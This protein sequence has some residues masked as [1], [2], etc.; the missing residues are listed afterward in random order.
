MSNARTCPRCGGELEPGSAE[1]LCPRCLLQ[2]A[3]E[4]APE[5]ERLVSVPEP[6][7]GTRIRYFGDYELLQ[8]LGH[9]GM[10]VVYQARQ[11]SLNRLVAVKL[12]QGGEF[13]SPQ[14]IQRFRTEAEAAARL[15]HPNIVAIHE[16][17][18]YRGQHYFSMDYV[19]GPT[20]EEQVR[21]GP[22]PPQ[23]AAALVRTMA[24]AIHYAH[25]QGI[26]H[27]DLKPSNVLVD[28]LDQPRI[29]D[30]GLAKV[31]T[32]DSELTLTGQPL[33]SPGYMAPEQA[34]G[35]P[36]ELGPHSDLYALGAV[37]YHLLT[38]RA[39]F[40]AETL[41][42]VL[43]Q[44]RETEPV[45][46]RSLNPSVPRDLETI[47]LKCLEKEPHRRYR[48]AKDLAE[49]LGR[50]AAGKPILARPVSRPERLWRW[51]RRQPVQAS[52]AAALF[53]VIVL[54]FT[55][56]ILQWRQA[57]QARA[58]ETRMRQEA[59]AGRKDARTEAAKSQQVARFLEEMLEGVGPEVALGRDTTLMRAILD[60]TADRVSK[61]LTDQPEVAAQLQSTI[62]NTYLRLGVFDKAEAI[63]REA[64]RL[65][66]L[67]RGETNKA[68]AAS[69]NTLARILLNRR[70]A[71]DFAHA[72]ALARRAL[73]I[74][75]SISDEE[76]AEIANSWHMLGSALNVQGRK[77][78]AE[79]AHERA[80]AI[81]RRVLKEH[82]DVAFSLNNLSWVYIDQGKF[83]QAR[84]A[85][86]EALALETNLFGAEHPSIATSL[87]SLGCV[88]EWQGRL[89]EAESLER[90]ALAM[91]EKLLP[92]EH[93]DLAQSLSTLAHLLQR[94]GRLA[95]A[96]TLA[97]DALVMRRKLFP[98]DHPQVLNSV[99]RLADI[100]A[101]QSKLAEAVAVWREQLALVK[102]SAAG[103][104]KVVVDLLLN[105][106]N[107]LVDQG[108]FAAAKATVRE[109]LPLCLKRLE[110]APTIHLVYRPDGPELYGCALLYLATGDT[111]GYRTTAAQI[112][113]HLEKVVAGRG[114]FLAR[115]C[116]LAPDAVTNYAPLLAVATNALAGQTNA[117]E[118][119]YELHTLGALL[120]RAGRY[121]E[122]LAQLTEA[123]QLGPPA[124][125]YA[126]KTLPVRGAYFL[127]LTHAR[128]GHTNEAFEWFRRAS[129]LDPFAGGTRGPDAANVLWWYRLTLQLLRA[130]AE[131][132]L[133]ARAPQPTSS[134]RRD[135]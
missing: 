122:A 50:F 125:P 74:L 34:S 57:E 64:L 71:D 108:N 88:A 76:N 21:K 77:P 93:K 128:L 115:A 69:L 13:A 9:G 33:G 134:S 39:P 110:T 99:F 114:A 107:V 131:S 44:V 38:G 63:E 94:Q 96:E 25:G 19:E 17:G 117:T 32:G 98:P 14:F 30:F 89:T 31:L 103:N 101:D 7:P 48:S 75:Q 84:A 106:A 82:P 80:L 24:E 92:A 22:L 123:Y 121:P 130:E 113:A 27:R 102:Q 129:S 124:K 68:V 53:T 67:V 41:T 66:I 4:A 87:L 61:S 104:Q 58:N 70:A 62:A 45:R 8:E 85:L 26:L 42:E 132:V 60:K 112:V 100:L 28:R 51:S 135:E 118:S 10:G 15:Q 2:D 29:T 83:D 78:E 54:G 73:A 55:G 56:V 133:H 40:H 43:R 46:P 3:F 59:E 65:K 126:E 91:S 120:Y 23:R 119:R 1:G 86:V 49:E 5:T 12:I 16:V 111:N 105:L 72:E 52:L 35:K 36:G 81:R 79:A 37:L 109:A 6:A 11:V 20:L 127:A 90:E 95:E 18:E 97:H 47:C 116:T